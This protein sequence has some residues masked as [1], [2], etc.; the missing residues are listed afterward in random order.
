MK[1]FSGAMI[2][3]LEHYLTP[4]LEHGKPDIAA[5]HIGSNNV[6]YDNL[7]IDDLILAEN[8][9][10]IGTKCIVYGFE[11]VVISSSFVKEST[12]LSSLIWK[13]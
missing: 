3:Y 6:S 9:T 11:E 5:I 2:K 10:K 1:S 13:N 8:I 4:N 7:N 12:R